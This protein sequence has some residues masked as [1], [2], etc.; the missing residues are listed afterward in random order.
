MKTKLKS[1]LLCAALM[2][3]YAESTHAANCTSGA[4]DFASGPEGTIKFVNSDMM[5]CNGTFWVSLKPLSVSSSGPCSQAGRL[6]GQY[7][8]DG[9]DLYSMVSTS[10]P[11]LMSDAP[12]STSNNNVLSYFNGSM[13]IKVSGSW[14]IAGTCINNCSGVSVATTCANISKRALCESLPDCAW[15][16][17]MN[18]LP[19]WGCY[20]A[21][22]STA[23][24]PQDEI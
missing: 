1:I 11:D 22:G 18:Q 13:N 17:I 16:D 10:T 8:C 19:P 15:A 20:D 23:P 9:V 21:G 7:Y 14:K 5:Y 3:I 12:V 4:P 6:D 24:P 2:L